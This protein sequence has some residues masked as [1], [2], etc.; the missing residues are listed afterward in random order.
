[1]AKSYIEYVEG[2]C[3]RCCGSGHRPQYQHIHGGRCFLCGGK[4]LLGEAL[5]KKLNSYLK[6][7]DGLDSSKSE[8]WFAEKVGYCAREVKRLENEYILLQKKHDFIMV[9]VGI[10]KGATKPK[11]GTLKLQ[12][13]IAEINLTKG[14]WFKQATL[15]EDIS[16]LKIET[17]GFAETIA[18]LNEVLLKNENRSKMLR[19]DVDSYRDFA[20]ELQ[21]NQNENSLLIS[22]DIKA[23]LKKALPNPKENPI[24]R[25]LQKPV[26]VGDTWYHLYFGSLK[27]KSVH[28]NDSVGDCAEFEVLAPN[29]IPEIPI[30]REGNKTFIVNIDS[31]GMIEKDMR[32][33]MLWLA[34]NDV[35][36]TKPPFFVPFIQTHRDPIFTYYSHAD[37]SSLFSDGHSGWDELKNKRFM[38]I[39]DSYASKLVFR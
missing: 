29:G 20:E 11:E 25:A 24:L 15:E 21:R 17:T 16:K 19:V 9:T 18:A 22:D 23:L 3:T 1:M 33:E 34:K 32:G 2:T 5:C 7:L 13:I 28:P 12:K 6:E 26:K 38:A 27:V 30:L 36:Y 37:F 31:S 39:A 14:S 4:G 8:S 10:K 35:I